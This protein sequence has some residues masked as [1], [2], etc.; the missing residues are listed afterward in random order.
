MQFAKCNYIVTG[1]IGRIADACSSRGLHLNITELVDGQEQTKQ[2]HGS[3]GSLLKVRKV[4]N[5]LLNSREINEHGRNHLFHKR[6]LVCRCS[7]RLGDDSICRLH[8]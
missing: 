4:S 8:R 5:R 2:T 6:L 1:Q 7:W 3:F